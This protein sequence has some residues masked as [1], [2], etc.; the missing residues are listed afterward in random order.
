MRTI[1]IGDIHGCN[2]ALQ[3]LLGKL[4]PREEDTLILLGDLFDRGPESWEVLQ[5]VKQLADMLSEHFVLLRGN[6]EDY[7]LQ[8]KQSLFQRMVWD[9]VGRQATVNS[10]KR[11]RQR[12]EEAAPWIRAH[13]TLFHKG[14]GFQCVHAGVLVEPIEMNDTQTLIHD[15]LAALQNHYAGLLTIT[16]H[17]ALGA[18]TWFTGDGENVLQV[19]YGTWEE[20]P[21]RGILCIDTGCGKGG[22]L[23]GMVIEDGRFRLDCAAQ[24]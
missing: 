11:H 23:T 21:E 4:A 19:E 17:I 13:C 10:F 24:E 7:L 12:M 9:R 16:G 6:H 2:R 5:T 8:E 20:L 1:I 15:H 18:P 22:K 14:E 3:R